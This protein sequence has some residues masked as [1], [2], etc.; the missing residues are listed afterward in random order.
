MLKMIKEI[1]RKP[2]NTSFVLYYFCLIK[3]CDI[4]KI[5]NIYHVILQNSSDT[6][7]LT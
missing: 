3:V 4:Y 2:T 5:Y 6:K 1:K 7:N